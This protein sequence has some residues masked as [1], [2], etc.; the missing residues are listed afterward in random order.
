MIHP[1]GEWAYDENWPG[2]PYDPA[3]A[4][5]LLTEA[6]YRNGVKIK[7]MAV[8]G[9]GGG[10]DI[11]EAVAA[12]LN[13]AGINAEVDI[14]DPGRY[15]G[16]VF[17]KGWMISSSVLPASTTILWPLCRPGSAMNRRRTSPA[18]REPTNCSP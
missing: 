5:Q 18:S 15:W 16:S 3:K 14:A 17:G 12:N 10:K 2:R 6:G 7:L 9:A 4:K 13:Q 1:K 8:P 11:A